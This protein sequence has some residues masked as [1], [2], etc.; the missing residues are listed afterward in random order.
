MMDLDDALLSI[1]FTVKEEGNPTVDDVIAVR[2]GLG[3]KLSLTVTRHE[4]SH[5][6]RSIHHSRHK[7]NGK[8]EGEILHY[9]DLTAKFSTDGTV[10]IEEIASIYRLFPAFCA[11]VARLHPE[12]MKTFKALHDIREAAAGR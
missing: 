11:E 1:G 4:L 3:N 9:T 6:L 7:M 10:P 12:A 5:P 2:D 8:E